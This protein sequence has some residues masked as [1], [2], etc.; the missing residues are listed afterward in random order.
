[1]PTGP[2]DS[3]APTGPHSSRGPG[4]RPLKAEITGSNPVCGTNPALVLLVDVD[5]VKDR[6][7]FPHVLVRSRSLVVLGQEHLAPAYDVAEITALAAATVAWEYLALVG[8]M[9][10]A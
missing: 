3:P 6:L 9:G 5:R 1:M 7:H 8:S 2:A 4:H 10:T